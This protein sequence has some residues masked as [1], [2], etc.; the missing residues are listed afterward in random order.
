[1]AKKRNIVE[2]AERFGNERALRV[3]RQRRFRNKKRAE[4]RKTGQKSFGFN[5]GGLTDY[6]K[7]LL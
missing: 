2:I 1:M 6:Y 7:D 5:K 3:F 4:E